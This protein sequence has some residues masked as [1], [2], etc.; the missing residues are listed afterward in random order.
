MF[1]VAVELLGVGMAAGHHHRLLG[2]AQ[3][4][5]SQP[6]CVPPCQAVEPIDR[7]VQLASVGK[8]MALDCTVVSTVT[9]PL[10]AARRSHAPSA[11]LSAKSRSS[12]SPSR[13]RQWLKSE[14]SCRNSCW[15]NSSSV[16]C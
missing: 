1:A 10:S 8:V 16:Q 3:V 6:Y 9:R 14:G 2:D 7:G 12:L 13:L 11:R 5:L 15:K 4:K